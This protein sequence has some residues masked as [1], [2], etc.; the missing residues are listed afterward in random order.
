MN[1][2]WLLIGLLIGLFGSWLSGRLH[3]SAFLK[4]Q[5]P[6]YSKAPAED[7]LKI[8]TGLLDWKIFHGYDHD[9]YVRNVNEIPFD[10]AAVTTKDQPNVELKEVD[11]LVMEGSGG[12]NST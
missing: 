9:L 1:A 10:K 5:Y 12:T 2:V 8:D 7:P 6:R 3:V 4:L 11:E